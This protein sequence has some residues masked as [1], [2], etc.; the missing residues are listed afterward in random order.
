MQ[1]LSHSANKDAINGAVCASYDW[2]SDSQFSRARATTVTA[3]NLPDSLLVAKAKSGDWSAFECL[4]WR[5]HERIY[6]FVWH[7]LRH[8]QASEDAT[9]EVFVRAWEQLPRLKNNDA[10]VTW[11]HQI[12]RHLCLDLLR[13]QAWEVPFD[14]T[15]SGNDEEEHEG[16]WEISSVAEETMLPTEDPEQQV[17]HNELKQAVHCAV[18]RLSP[19][20]REVIV[21][22]YFEDLS[23]AEIAQILGV[24][25]GTVLSRLAR[26]RQ[27][28]QKHLESLLGM[29]KGGRHR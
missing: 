2:E 6:T 24:P 11:L 15:G 18:G 27:A 8:P 25:V 29:P 5:Y 19:P 20:L 22:H 12:A 10:F 7:Y 21:L 26:A 23:V 1:R 28:L 3:D 17:L 4:F 16:D 9:Q 13:R 14:G